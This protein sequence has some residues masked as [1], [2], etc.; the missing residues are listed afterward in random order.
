MGNGQETILREK[1]VT[2]GKMERGT[3]EII[4]K[5]NHMEKE[6]YIIQTVRKCIVGNSKMEKQME[7]ANISIKMVTDTS[8]TTKTASDLEKE[9]TITLM[10]E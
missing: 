4:E 3:K 10:G 9:S 5:T 1:D 8:G 6:Y 7:K 2:L